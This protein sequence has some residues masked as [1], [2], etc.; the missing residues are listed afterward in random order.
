MIYIKLFDE[1]W[2][3]LKFQMCLWNISLNII[4]EFIVKVRKPSHKLHTGRQLAY[5]LE[6]P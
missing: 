1:I 4:I 2:L 3:I 6:N 5:G